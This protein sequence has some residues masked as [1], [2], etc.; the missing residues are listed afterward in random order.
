MTFSERR[1]A[2]DLPPVSRASR[3]TD[4]TAA[5]RWTTQTLRHHEERL[6]AAAA[7]GEASVEFRAPVP[8]AAGTLFVR[9]GSEI[10]PRAVSCAVVRMDLSTSSPVVRASSP[11]D[12]PLL[13]DAW[14]LLQ[15]LT[16][17]REDAVEDWLDPRQALDH[18]L[19]ADPARAGLAARQWGALTGG[20]DQGHVARELLAAVTG[21][22]LPPV[23]GASWSAWSA[24]FGAH[25]AA[26]AAQAGPVAAVDVSAPDVVRT[27]DF[28]DAADVS[29]LVEEVLDRQAEDVERWRSDPTGPTR[30]H[31]WAE[32]GRTVGTVTTSGP[33][34]DVAAAAVAVVLRR[35]PDGDVVVLDAYPE[36]PLDDGLRSRYPVAASVLAG[37]FGPG[38][39]RLDVRPWPAQ[40]ALL[41]GESPATLARWRDEVVR[42]LAHGDVPRAVLRLGGAVVPADTEGWLRRVLWRMDTFDAVAPA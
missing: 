3:W 23:E 7:R 20:S 35:G 21:S 17:F 30:G 14:D 26:A 6:R 18:A 34:L 32:V 13:E 37:W 38:T 1:P 11:D 28:D 39:P 25:L 24:W 15:V 5:N 2:L 9:A 31:V 19:A 16:R 29:G 12:L 41:S 42:L 4:A 8:P 27:G 36:V 10:E 33:E 22:D 40:R